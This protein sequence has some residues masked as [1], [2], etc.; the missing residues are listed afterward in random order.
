[1][2]LGLGLGFMQTLAYLDEQR[3][4]AAGLAEGGAQQSPLGAGEPGGRGER[5]R[6]ERKRGE[7]GG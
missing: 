6:G 5:V 3:R 4:E 7:E 2:G 1:M